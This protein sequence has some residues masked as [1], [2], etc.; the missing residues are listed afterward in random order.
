MTL[1]SLVGRHDDAIYRVRLPSQQV[2]RGYLFT[3]DFS[4][5]EFKIQI[6]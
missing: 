1:M 3:K 2:I 6:K 5:V 4:Y